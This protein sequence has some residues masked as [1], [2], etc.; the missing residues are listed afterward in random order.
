VAWNNCKFCSKWYGNENG[1]ENGKW[2]EYRINEMALQV[3]IIC[4]IECQAYKWKEEG[5]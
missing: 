2:L 1:N 4:K 5:N 3:K